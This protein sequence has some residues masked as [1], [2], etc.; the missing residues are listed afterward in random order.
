MKNSIDYQRVADYHVR[1]GDRAAAPAT[2]VKFDF[3]FL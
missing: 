2:D 1:S 3:M